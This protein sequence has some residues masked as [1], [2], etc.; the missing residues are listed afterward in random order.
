[1]QEYVQKGLE[2]AAALLM[3]IGLITALATIVVKFTKGEEDDK[4]VSEFKVKYLHFLMQLPSI[5][6]PVEKV[7]KVIELVEEQKEK[8]KDDITKVS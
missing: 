4:K 5:G 8:T 7:K 2:I 3:I 1:M 6:F